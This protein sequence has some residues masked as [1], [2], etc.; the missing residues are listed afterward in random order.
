MKIGILKADSVLPQFQGEFGDYPDMFVARLS[1]NSEQ[2]VSFQTYDVEHLEYPADID[3]CDG[4]VITGSKKSVYDDEPWIH[5]LEEYV[6]TLDRA[7]KPLVGV[8]FGHQLVAQALGGQTRPADVGWGVGVHTS[9]LVSE[10]DFMQPSLNQ[11]RVLV[12]HKDQVTALPEG[13]ERLASSEFCPNAMYQVGEHIFCLQGH[14]EFIK[15]YSESL[16]NLRR[17]ILGETL[18]EEG[19]ESLE[20]PLDSDTLARWMLNFLQSRA[21]VGV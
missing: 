2:E 6:R 1:A 9:E 16:M 21:V 11:I 12:S 13:S 10:K 17:E 15:P 18:F 5:Q 7:R 4:Y 3:D 14:P 19:V 20:Q 8:C